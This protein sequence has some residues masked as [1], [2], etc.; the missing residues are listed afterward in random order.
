MNIRD[1]YGALRIFYISIN[2]MRSF[3]IFR[4]NVPKKKNKLENDLIHGCIEVYL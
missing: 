1:R 2:V 4:V 3:I